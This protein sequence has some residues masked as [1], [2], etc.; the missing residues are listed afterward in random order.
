MI[1]FYLV[2]IKNNDFYKCSIHLENR[3]DATDRYSVKYPFV[4]GRDFLNYRSLRSTGAY[5]LMCLKVDCM[6]L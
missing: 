2:Y 6:L 4:F 5:L 1:F 3:F